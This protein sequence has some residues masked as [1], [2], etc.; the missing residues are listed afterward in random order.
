[1]PF[2]ITPKA[3]T[4]IQH[5][6]LSAKMRNILTQANCS[7][8]DEKGLKCMEYVHMFKACYYPHITIQN[9]NIFSIHIYSSL[10]YGTLRVCPW[11]Q[12]HTQTHRCMTKY[13]WQEQR[14]NILS[15]RFFRNRRIQVNHS[16]MINT[17]QMGYDESCTHLANSMQGENKILYKICI[18][19]LHRMLHIQ[20]NC[21]T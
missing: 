10:F 11:I 15:G 8:K 16:C 17:E 4:R 3:V 6:T 5:P 12:E 21:C 2:H 13:Y 18:V 7:C 1:M 19:I 9:S 20:V 14:N